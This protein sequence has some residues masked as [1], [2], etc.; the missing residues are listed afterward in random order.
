MATPSPPY[1]MGSPLEL[2]CELAADSIPSM[3]TTTAVAGAGARNNKKQ[4]PCPLP[5]PAASETR[6]LSPPQYSLVGG[7]DDL[8]SVKRTSIHALLNATE[9][10][11]KDMH[12]AAGPKQQGHALARRTMV[13]APLLLR[14]VGQPRPAPYPVAAGSST[15]AKIQQQQK[16]IH[17]HNHDDD[18]QNL[19]LLL[20]ESEKKHSCPHHGCGRGFKRLEHL[21]R[22]LRIHTGEKPFQCK[23]CQKTFARSDNLTQHAKV[24]ESSSSSSS[25]SLSLSPSPVITSAVQQQPLAVVVQ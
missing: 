11:A 3:P 14:M 10:D 7:I 5:S 1:R 2:L 17:N 25:M 13:L 16:H 6:P 15:Q 24:H 20:S 19:L 4:V 23:D 21:R 18:H 9:M 8:P 12:A 22:H